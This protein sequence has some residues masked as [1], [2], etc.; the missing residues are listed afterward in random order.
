MA[1]N[2]LDY[3][4]RNIGDVF[5]TLRTDTT[6]NG[7]VECNGTEYVAADFDIVNEMNNPYTLCI[8]GSIPSV[9]YVKYA[10]L[11][12][13]QGCCPYF[14]INQSSGK[15]KVPTLNNVFVECGNVKQLA[16]Y[17]AP[18]LPN[19]T[20]SFCADNTQVGNTKEGQSHSPTGAFYRSETLRNYDLKSDSSVNNGGTLTFDAN[21]VNKIYGSSSTVQPKA[22]MLRPMVQLVTSVGLVE[23]GEEEET[24]GEELVIPYKFTP[25]TP[26]KSLEVNANFE[27]VLRAIRSQSSSTK[28]IVYTEGDQEISGLK[29]FKDP[30]HFTQV[31]IIPE[32]NAAHGGRLYFHFGGNS[33]STASLMEA[34][35]GYLSINQDPPSSDNTRKIAT[36]A[37]VNSK[38]A[39]AGSITGSLALP[40]W[41]KFSNGLIIQWGQTLTSAYKYKSAFVVNFPTA[42]PHACLSMTQNTSIQQ[43]WGDKGDSIGLYGFTKTG[44]TVW[45]GTERWKPLLNWIAVGY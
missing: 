44:F 12:E 33:I 25:G 26:A 24:P 31:D 27:Y 6:L 21:R 1:H 17:L 11:V 10:S 20:G 36:T 41:T 30:T 35:K 15:F 29:V 43:D 3:A 32:L 38:I 40:G 18:G 28:P 4:S 8:N 45:V 2:I 19:I 13:S 5:Y 7:A 34:A 39:S 9:D 23:E 37:W 42:F 16:K 22:V 14:G